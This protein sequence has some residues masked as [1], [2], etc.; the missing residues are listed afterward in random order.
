M[1]EAVRIARRDSLNENDRITLVLAALCHDMGKPFTT[2]TRE[3]GRI[4]SPA[5]AK[6][7]VEPAKAFMD[8]IGTPEQTAAQVAKLVQEHMVIAG[9]PKMSNKAVIKLANR[10]VPSS[11]EMLVKI[12][13]ADESGRPPLPKATI[14]YELETQ[15]KELSVREEP[16]KPIL[17]GRDFIE[18]G[19]KPGPHIGAALNLCVEKQEE[20]V[21]NSREEALAWLEEW[22]EDY[23]S[24]TLFCFSYKV[25][26]KLYQ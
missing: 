21:I 20:G 14:P 3:D 7:G 13:E 16:M 22:F 23:M 17:M 25:V 18:K 2:S 10:I 24:V 1:D 8:S 12:I 5:H 9:L 4:V 26:C 11:I 19:V 15:A 6:A